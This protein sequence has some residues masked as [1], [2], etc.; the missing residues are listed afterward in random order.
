MA[1]KDTTIRN[2]ITIWFTDRTTASFWLD[3]QDP[4]GDPEKPW[5]GFFEWFRR[6]RSPVFDFGHK[7]GFT[8]V[9]RMHIVRAAV[10]VSEV[11]V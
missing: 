10:T 5:D 8:S 7:E 2:Q 3:D 9:H 11:E 4:K 1:K 6:K